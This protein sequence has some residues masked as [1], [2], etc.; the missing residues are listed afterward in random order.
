MTIFIPA[1]LDAGAPFQV[2]HELTVYQAA[3]I[4]TGRHPH[5]GFLRDG[6]VDDHLKFLSAGIPDQPKSRERI[7]A[8]RSWDVYCE[9]MKKIEAG[10]IIP[11]RA[12][13]QRSGQL[14]PVL[15]VI[16]LA[17]V[18]RL[19]AERG[20]RPRY[21]RHNHV[22]PVEAVEAPPRS[23]HARDRARMALDEIYPRG[24]PDAATEPNLVLYKKVGDWLKGKRLPNVSD[25]TILRAA[26]RR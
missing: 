20:E 9:L 17:D 24:I 22:E 19:A 5:E 21:L 25:S 12:H 15:T 1:P 3:M 7:R 18:A 6:T 23:Q 13:Y 26:G 10:T 16:R 14:N 2:G 8:Q 11:V 4:Y